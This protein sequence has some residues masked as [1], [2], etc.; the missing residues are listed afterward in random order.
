MIV[1][2]YSIEDDNSGKYDVPVSRAVTM[3]SSVLQYRK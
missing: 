3:Q 2:L 1:T